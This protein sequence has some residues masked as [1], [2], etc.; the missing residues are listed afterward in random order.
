MYGNAPVVQL[1]KRGFTLIELLVVIAII[2]VLVAIL[3]PAVQ[4]AREAARRSSCNNNL[5]Q[6][7]LAIANYESTFS[8]YPAGRQ[9]CDGSCTGDP[10]WSYY[11]TSAFVGL[12]P[13][14]DQTALFNKY[15]TAN[16]IYNNSSTTWLA[17]ANNKAFVAS[18][19]ATYV[20]PSDISLP[21]VNFTVGADTAPT[22]VSS[23]GLSAG[24]YGPSVTT[25]T[26]GKFDNT[27]MFVYKYYFG[28]KDALDGLS[29][30]FFVGEVKFADNTTKPNQWPYFSRHT[31]VARS[32]ENPMNT[33]VGAGT[34]FEGG[35]ACFGSYHVGGAQ[36]V[37]GDG[38][39]EFL[40]E[41]IA[42]PVY[43]A[44]STRKGGETTNAL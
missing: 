18:R 26:T 27:G 21:T 10:T 17:S 12:L 43:R 38:R 5:K 25:N 9:G 40:S 14:I 24:T 37:F 3:L 19:P 44:L 13:Y 2:A 6:I 28:V 32:T 7:G 1:R 39:V 41:N 20:C 4:Q 16:P 15:D 23:Y 22:A 8:L 30:T 34:Q 31:A 35:N 36:F 33:K 29:N 42:L 11:G